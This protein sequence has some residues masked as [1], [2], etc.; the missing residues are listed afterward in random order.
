M[1]ASQPVIK[2]HVD[3]SLLKF[4]QQRHNVAAHTASKKYVDEA[5]N[6]E[7]FDFYKTDNEDNAQWYIIIIILI[8]L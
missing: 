7:D 1:T 5:P 8:Y 3:D 4:L 6:Q 2:N